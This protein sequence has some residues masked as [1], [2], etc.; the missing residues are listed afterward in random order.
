ML[1]DPTRGIL[2]TNESWKILAW[3]AEQISFDKRLKSTTFRYSS[4]KIRY[5]ALRAD[6]EESSIRQSRYMSRKLSSYL[7]GERILLRNI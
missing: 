1:Q 2:R 6:D 3:R 7:Q 5:N 4:M